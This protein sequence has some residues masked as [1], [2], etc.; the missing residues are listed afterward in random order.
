MVYLDSLHFILLSMVMVVMSSPILRLPS[1]ILVD[2]EASCVSTLNAG[3]EC[4]GSQAG[5]AKGTSFHLPHLHGH[6][7]GAIV[8]YLRPYFLLQL[9][10]GVR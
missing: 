4:H 7:G 8:N 1:L 10:K 9:H 6:T 5:A 2:F 3:Q